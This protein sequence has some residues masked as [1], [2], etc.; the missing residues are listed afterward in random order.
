MHMRASKSMRCTRAAA[1]KKTVLKF[2]AKDMHRAGDNQPPRRQF[3]GLVFGMRF[4]QPFSSSL[5]QYVPC[6]NWT[7]DDQDHFLNGAGTH[8]RGNLVLDVCN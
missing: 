4:L 2:V 8:L 7:W 3:Q 6:E 5:E 1:V